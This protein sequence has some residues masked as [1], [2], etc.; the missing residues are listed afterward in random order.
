MRSQLWRMTSQGMLVHEG[1]VPLHGPS[2]RSYTI[3]NCLVLDI[4]GI[5]PQHGAPIPLM[6][7]KSDERRH[8]T[9]TWNFS[10]VCI[11]DGDDVVFLFCEHCT[12]IVF[13]IV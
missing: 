13:C 12:V 3:A 5:A 9:Q 7:R 2:K 1:S 8:A 10:K 6:L 4:H 11:A